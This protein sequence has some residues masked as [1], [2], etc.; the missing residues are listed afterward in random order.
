MNE[1]KNYTY[2]WRTRF[3]QSVIVGYR[4]FKVAYQ[5]LGRISLTPGSKVGLKFQH[6]MTISSPAIKGKDVVYVPTPMEAVQA[7]IKIA[8]LKPSDFVID[9]GSGDGRVVIEAAK[10]CNYAQ[11]V[12]LNPTLLAQARTAARGMDNAEFYE[13]DFMKVNLDEFN[14]IFLYLLPELNLKLKPI[15]QRLAPGT[16]IV[17]H[18]F[19]MGDWMPDSA[20]RVGRDSVFLWI[21]K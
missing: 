4:M 1:F 21:V 6:D 8:D 18:A 5:E 12:E 10:H 17:S 14:V 19:S 9:L 13:Q 7:M 20:V 15:L 3:W 16:R 11:G 2:S